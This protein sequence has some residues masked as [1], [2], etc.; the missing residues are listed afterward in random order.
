[1]IDQ[2]RKGLVRVECKLLFVGHGSMG[3]GVCMSMEGMGV[4]VVIASTSEEQLGGLRIKVKLV[5]GGGNFSLVARD[6]VREEGGVV[7]FIMVDEPSDSWMEAWQ[8][9]W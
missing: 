4:D 5:E 2:P 1:M 3:I 6:G 9:L 8:G 7:G